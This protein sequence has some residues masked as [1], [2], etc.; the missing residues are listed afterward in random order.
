ME[1]DRDYK[2]SEI[3]ERYQTKP[4]SKKYIFKFSLPLP[5]PI[6]CHSLHLH[7]RH[8]KSNRSYKSWSANIS[9]MANKTVYCKHQISE[10]WCNNTPLLL[11]GIVDSRKDIY[12]PLEYVWPSLPP[13][14]A[15]LAQG[16]P[17]Y[18]LP[19]ATD[20]PTSGK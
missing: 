5:F 15:I 16:T 18:N 1:L 12:P 2:G 17:D 4:N 19:A 11:V 10:L 6:S 13:P 7:L 20:P 8:T 9:W 3:N 14:P